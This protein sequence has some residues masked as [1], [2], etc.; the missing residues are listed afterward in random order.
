L[1]V[2]IEDFSLWTESG[3]YVVNKIS[4]IFGNGDD[5]YGLNDGLEKLSAGEIPKPYTTA[6]TLS[7]TPT[8]WTIPSFPTWALNNTGYGSNLCHDKEIVMVEPLTLK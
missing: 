8:G 3:T 7:K 2:T 5:V 4:N 6:I 1:N